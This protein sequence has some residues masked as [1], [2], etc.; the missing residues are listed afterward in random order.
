M[1]RVRMGKNILKNILS[2]TALL[3]MVVSWCAACT[4]DTIE[5]EENRVNGDNYIDKITVSMSSR[6]TQTTEENEAEDDESDG[7]TE[8]EGEAGEGKE[9][10]DVEIIDP[11][12]YKIDDLIPYDLKFDSRSVI[13]VSQMTSETP[14]F[15]NDDVIYAY[16]YIPDSED[17]NWDDGYNFTPSG[18][19]NPLEWFKIGNGGTYHG[20]FSLYALHFPLETSLRQKTGPDGT[21]RYSVLQDQSTV[22][23]LMKSDILGA[24]HAT[25]TLFSRL[26]FRMHHLMTYLRIRLYVPVYDGELHTGFGDGALDHA[27]LDHVTPDFAVEWSANRSSDTQ[28]PAIVAL[29]G[30]DSIIM[31]RHASDGIVRKIKYKQFLRDNYYDQGITGDYDYV[32]TYDFSVLLPLQRG[33]VDENGE[34]TNFLGTDFLSFYI[35]SNSGILTRYYFTQSLGGNPDNNSDS[36][37][38]VEVGEEVFQ[39]MQLM[40]PRVGNKM[41]YVGSVVNPWSQRQ[42]S[43]VLKP[44]EE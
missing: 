21:I 5:K 4:E 1:T 13:F 40:V 8:G 17:A 37:N 39:Y 16:S 10:D 2:F 19:D 30:D 43:I 33:S 15:Q 18:S 41:I 7:D 32:R 12:D 27:T 11:Y 24:Y 3:L 25:P 9:P 29:S 6:N 44:T 14:A 34:E 38:T 35:R 42:T 31:Y 36:S 23:K 22:E 26:R 20:G 28:G